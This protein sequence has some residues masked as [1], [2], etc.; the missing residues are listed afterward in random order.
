[1]AVGSVIL[2]YLYDYVRVDGEPNITSSTSV[3]S[4]TTSSPFKVGPIVQEAKLPFVHGKIMSYIKKD[5]S[6]PRLQQQ[7]F[8]NMNYVMKY[9]ICW[10]RSFCF[11]LF[12]DET[13]RNIVIDSLTSRE[14]SPKLIREFMLTVAYYM[15]YEVSEKLATLYTRIIHNPSA[16]YYLTHDFRFQKL[17]NRYKQE[18]TLEELWLLFINLL[19]QYDVKKFPIT[20]I[21]G[22]YGHRYAIQFFQNVWPVLTGSK[23]DFILINMTTNDQ[24]L[25]PVPGGV[26]NPKFIMLNHNSFW[27]INPTG[28]KTVLFA[29]YNNGTVYTLSSMIMTTYFNWAVI[30]ERSGHQFGIYKCNRKFYSEHRMHK[31]RERMFLEYILLDELLPDTIFH[32]FRYDLSGSIRVCMYTRSMFLISEQECELLQELSKILRGNVDYPRIFAILAYF[33]KSITLNLFEVTQKE[34]FLL[35]KI[36]KRNRVAPEPQK[37]SEPKTLKLWSHMYEDSTGKNHLGFWLHSENGLWDNK[38]I[39]RTNICTIENYDILSPT[40][41][42]VLVDTLHTNLIPPKPPQQ[43]SPAYEKLTSKLQNNVAFTI[44]TFTARNMIQHDLLQNL[45]WMLK[46]YVMDDPPDGAG[47]GSS[48]SK[49]KVIMIKKTG[50]KY[51]VY[52]SEKGTYIRRKNE[53]IY[54]KHIKGTY[55]YV[56]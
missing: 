29:K 25:F 28:Q 31:L 20:R 56:R 2:E 33:T 36:F 23:T 49:S 18:I 44:E 6:S 15:K 42:T 9:P 14:T 22:Y 55:V 37:P 39:E 5:Y 35:K 10:F 34:P 11:M 45:F 16:L 17:N 24:L 53:R 51:K 38:K 52:N 30:K 47:G 50:K 13:M 32:K 46:K 26:P 3:T 41:P 40:D 8:D 43:Q 21:E 7:C 27:K 54:L 4:A 48:R 12:L 19:N 1:M